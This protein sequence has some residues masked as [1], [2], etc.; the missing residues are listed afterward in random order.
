MYLPYQSI[1]KKN[2]SSAYVPVELLE[3]QKQGLST[4]DKKTFNSWDET[5]AKELGVDKD[6]LWANF[7]SEQIDSIGLA[8]WNFKNK[9]AFII[10]DETGIGKGRILSGICRWAFLNNK[11]VLFFTEREHLFS[12][13]W[14][15]LTDTETIS[16]LKN[17][18]VF[19][20]TT[21]VYNQN[22][23]I[24][25]RGTS[26]LVKSIEENGFD[27]DTNLV[28]TNYSQVSLK[29]HKKNKKHI[30]ENYAEDQVII[31]DESHNATGDSNTKKFL[32]GLLEKTPCVVY[33]SA[34]FIKDESQLDLYQKTIQF[35][36]NTLSLFKKLLKND[37]DLIL[38][39]I[40][41]YELTRK[42]Q[43]WRREHEPLSVGWKTII[44]EKTDEQE[45][46]IN[47]YSHIINSLFL[48]TKMMSQH[49][50]FS[51]LNLTSNWFSYG[52]TINRLSR[53]LLLLIKL[54][55]LIQ[56]VKK[57]LENNHKAVIVI[58]STF[59]SLI[60]KIIEHQTG[61][62]NEEAEDNI[63]IS[64][65]TYDINFSKVLHYIIDE[66][67]GKFIKERKTQGEIYTLYQELYNQANYFSHLFISPIDQIIDTL[68]E[69]SIRCNEISG[70]TFRI[71]NNNKVEKIQKAPK[72]K[73]VKEFNDGDVNVIILT[74][75]GASGLSLHASAAF[76][77]Q[78][79]RDLFELEITNRPTYRLQFIGR[80]HRKN[81]VVEPEFYG[82][83]TQLPFEQRIL[84]VEKQK[85]EKMQ[86]HISGDDEKHDQENIH[87]FYTD[88]CNQ[89]AE[90]FLKNHRDLAIQ[91]GISLQGDK[92][93]Y[94]FVDSILKR[95]IVLNY[96][97]QNKLYDYLIY[98]TECEKKLELRKNR[99]LSSTIEGIKNFWHQLDL[100][101][102]EKFKKIYGH[103]PQNSI[104]QFLFPWVGLMT[105][106]T[107][108]HTD[109]VYSDL[110]KTEI[111]SNLAK[112]EQVSKYFN[113]VGQFFSGNSTY[114]K[115]FLNQQIIPML[116]SL[117]IGTSVGIRNIEGNIFGYINNIEIPPIAKPYEYSDVCILQIKTVNPHIHESIKYSN[118]EY[119]VTLKELLESENITVYEQEID[120]KKFD[121][122]KRDYERTQLT[123]VGHPVYMEFLK[124]AYGLGETKYADSFGR[125][126]MYVLL[127]D[128]MKADKLKSLKKPI[129]E[130][131]KIMEGL[132]AKKIKSLTTSWQDPKDLKPSLKL[133]STTGGYNLYIAN[134]V[135]KN[136][137]FIDFPLRKKLKN[138]KGQAFGFET[139]FI[140]YNEVRSLL[141]TLEIRD[142]IW[143]ID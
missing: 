29:Q 120:W 67:V 71:I 87:N 121:R 63:S 127:P 65:G 36:S 82:I 122:P 119:Y 62:D 133:E 114:G 94:Y 141:F 84:N 117:R 4:L 26:K 73:L 103:L 142:V 70:R 32:L 6:K 115:E 76:K 47:N 137:T 107:K 41:T 128:N 124:Q 79:V 30:L 85:I 12:D 1:S 83:V 28:M 109:P 44:C 55:D 38:R 49:P 139:F 132:I 102:Q 69:S 104:N 130:A 110:L 106:K 134:E 42:L 20:S 37:K 95:C 13:F 93:D 46:L 90:L 81:Q 54:P 14:R 3:A 5:V 92:E 61:I 108:Y 101:Q 125:K 34:T 56:A 52:A 91:M 24:V 45:T 105:L 97:Q 40:F 72:S 15:D 123:W 35:D 78:R 58:D 111:A 50:D 9:R 60:N 143:F 135:W 48:L 22:N 59:S 53:N 10:A 129:Y 43:F 99:G 75:A 17:P 96:E 74:R 138:R 27:E 131:N 98:A 100:V 11:K 39:K 64:D 89:A 77:D 19:H 113:N 126:N 112:N 16:L 23:E 86:S 88:Y 8:L 21:K 33:S 7:S 66:I 51:S 140:P 25:L 31:L 68:R 118:K 18:V 2:D 136:S 80:V 57:S 116:K